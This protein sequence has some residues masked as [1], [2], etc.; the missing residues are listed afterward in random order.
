MAL[1][2]L[3]MALYLAVF[4]AL[5]STLA[6]LPAKRFFR[7]KIGPRLDVWYMPAFSII[8]VITVLPLV[9]MVVKSPGEVIYI[10]PWPWIGALFLLQGLVGLWSLRAFIDAP[11]RFLISAQLAIPGQTGFQSLKVRGIY[12]F[13]RD[14]FLLSGLLL[15][16]LTPFMTWNMAVLYSIASIYLILGSLHWERRLSAQFKDEYLDYQKRVPRVIPRGRRCK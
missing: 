2:T 15:M 13:I 4:A 5:H 3:H 14:P 1:E 10:V 6:S 12:C 7:K 16:W 11:H 9:Y 8:A